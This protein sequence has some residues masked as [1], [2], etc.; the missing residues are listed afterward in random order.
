[1]DTPPDSELEVLRAEVARLRTELDEATARESR[2]AA[3]LRASQA[4]H[5]ATIESLPFDFWA[6]DREGYCIS[7]NSTTRARWGEALHRRVEDMDLPSD[8]AATWLDNNRRALGGEIVRADVTFVVADETRHLHN[9]LAPI[10]HGDEIV[11]TLGVNID[12]TE[13]RRAEAE[14]L[15]LERRLRETQRL[16][17]VGLLAGGVA[18][19]INNI[20]MIVLATTSLARRHAA[21]TANL[22]DD[23]ATIE[24]ACRRAAALCSQLLVVAGKGQLALEVVDLSTL[25]AETATLVRSAVPADIEVRC[26]AA[27]GSGLVV[28][29]DATQIRQLV[30]NLVL[31]ASEAIGARG[32]TIAID[33]GLAPAAAVEALTTRD[34][35]LEL[36]PS[37]EHVVLEIVDTG[38]GMSA[39]TRARIF[40]PFFST[41]A[42][43]RGLGLA[44]ALGVVRAHGGGLDVESRPGTGSTFRVY[45]PR[46]MRAVEPPP[47]DAALEAWR[48]S[49]TALIVDDDPAVAN[50]A[51]RMLRMLGFETLIA[52]GGHAA[53]ELYREHPGI[54]LVLLDLMMPVLDGATTLGL[55]RARHAAL[56]VVLMSGF[57]DLAEPPPQ[58]PLLHKP[59]TV[60][61][62]ARTVRGAVMARATQPR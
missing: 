17:T 6:R 48:G 51:A 62:L 33:L 56:P 9:I 50:A 52:T 19:D 57:H 32:G 2:L 1:M 38:D 43:G 25:V 7:H 45:L 49:G 8:V 47:C 11:G 26:A 10:R 44:A 31:N 58:T 54:A 41:K 21:G 46:A 53:L 59:F 55:L 34:A 13:L 60:D 14:Q 3:D 18:H 28:E 12:L 61:E 29:A 35:G 37:R 40:E 30:M 23:F 5:A 39:E 20:V 27:G 4:L 42:R 36:D 15:R 22:D 24:T 16:E